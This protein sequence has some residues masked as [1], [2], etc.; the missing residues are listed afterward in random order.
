MNERLTPEQEREIRERL[1]QNGSSYDLLTSA[2]SDIRALLAEIDALRHERERVSKAIA[3]L[4]EAMQALARTLD[5]ASSERTKILEG[6]RKI[7][8]EAYRVL[9]RASYAMNAALKGLADMQADT[10]RAVELLE[11]LTRLKEDMPP[12][13]LR[14]QVE[15][16]L[17]YLRPLED[18]R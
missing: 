2:T 5:T 4:E 11:P 15:H 18:E 14:V 17:R 9:D 6:A 16:A 12:M 1:H 7:I 13:A 10:A 8:N 3:G